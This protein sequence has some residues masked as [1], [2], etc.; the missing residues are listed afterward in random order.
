MNGKTPANMLWPPFRF[1]SIVAIFLNS[2]LLFLFFFAGL[3]E[4]I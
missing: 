2:V 3:A 1:L 4:H